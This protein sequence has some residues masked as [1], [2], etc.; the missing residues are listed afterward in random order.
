M[1]IFKSFVCSGLINQMAFRLPSLN[2]ETLT[3]FPFPI[4]ETFFPVPS[5][6]LATK[7]PSKEP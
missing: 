1:N 2:L 7:V 3:L 5:S 6:A 4:Q